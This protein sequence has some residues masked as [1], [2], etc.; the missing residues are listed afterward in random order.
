ML[1]N[2]SSTWDGLCGPLW[3]DSVWEKREDVQLRLLSPH[4]PLGG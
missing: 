1:L 4:L 2:G 3:P